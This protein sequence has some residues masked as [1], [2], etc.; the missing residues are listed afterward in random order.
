MKFTIR[1]MF[2]VITVL[3][4]GIAG[5]LAGTSKAHRQWRVVLK[6]HN[7]PLSEVSKMYL[8]PPPPADTG[9]FDKNPNWAPRAPLAE[10]VE[11]P[12]AA[13]ERSKNLNGTCGRC[14]RP[15][16]HKNVGVKMHSTPLGVGQACFPLCEKC[17]LSLTP[18]QRL[19]YYEDLHHDWDQYKGN[20]VPLEVFRAAVLHENSKG[21]NAPE[22]LPN[23][24]VEAWEK[25]GG[26]PKSKGI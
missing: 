12:A 17:W 23:E 11:H 25:A 15:W 7:E 3:S 4:V 14:Q 8:I 26:M 20:D 2:V 16:F 5:F 21:D 22:D 1:Q 10:V 19:P 13:A 18:E 6:L 24:V 9:N